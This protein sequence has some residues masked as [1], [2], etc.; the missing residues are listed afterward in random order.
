MMKKIGYIVKVF[1]RY[2]MM[3]Y[4]RLAV[5][6]LVI[7]VGSS[8]VCGGA[9]F[10]RSEKQREL[11]RELD[12]CGN[13]DVSVYNIDESRDSVLK[14]VSGIKSVGR[15]YEM[16]Y[17]CSGGQNN[18]I[19]AAA[20]VD[21][22]SKDIY[23][24]TC[25]DG[26]YPLN[27][28]EIAIDA[29]TAKKMGIMPQ[30]GETVNLTLYDYEKRPVSV[31]Q[32]KITGIFESSSEMALGGDLRQPDI[33][34]YSVPKVFLN[35]TKDS[36]VNKE[37]LFIQSDE[38]DLMTLC[39]NLS[40]IGI[41]AER[42]VVPNGRRYAYI[43]ALGIIDDIW[44]NYDNPSITNIYKAISDGNTV[45]D[46]YSLV[47]IPVFIGF[48]IIMVVTALNTLIRNIIKDRMKL[49]G[50][51]RSQGITA[52]EASV[53]MGIELV[54][55]TT[56]FS[57][58]GIA[59]GCGLHKVALCIVNAITG[60]GFKT[61]YNVNS[62]ISAVTM[63][64]YMSSFVVI[65]A[66]MFIA[67]IPPLIKSARLKPVNLLS[68]NADGIINDRQVR[69]S[70]N[71]KWMPILNSRMH[72]YSNGILLITVIC[73]SVAF[74]GY[75]YFH[76][77]ADKNNAEYKYELREAG[78]D[79][80][81]YTAGRNSHIA[82]G[83]LNTEN[84]HDCGIDRNEY[85]MISS[86]GYT[87][88]SYAIMKNSSTKLAYDDISDDMY[89]LMKPYSVRKYYDAA[90]DYERVMSEAENEVLKETGYSE[91]YIFSVPTVG[92]PADEVD[93]LSGCVIEGAIDKEVMSEGSRVIVAV[94]PEFKELAGSF[95]SVGDNLPLSDILLSPDEEI[96]NFGDASIYDSMTP[97]Y[98]N[99]I[100][101]EETEEYADIRG[102]AIGKRKDIPVSV[103]AIIVT[104]DSRY[105]CDGISIICVDSVYEKWGLP[106]NKYTEIG[107]DIKDDADIDKV[108]L[109]WSETISSCK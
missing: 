11:E 76:A 10:V 87:R 4:K 99:K 106:D 21:E 105:S 60:I 8:A 64:P 52:C 56:V 22:M 46:F 57:V 3:H 82:M 26:R 44:E 6:M 103:G 89:E 50:V 41:P 12:I 30:I 36:Y 85:E 48:I 70:K 39:R 104:E 75:T 47:I 14:D 109:D 97:V 68:G 1:S 16:G 9:L 49:F 98:E 79:E 55:L 78:L 94:S 62:I 40:Q 90:S 17:V 74:L 15:Y 18:Y 101:D 66:G 93:R 29:S 84:R 83:N 102:Y 34:N 42:M 25:T 24:M 72:L 43:Y 81:D 5:Y 80:F 28:D 107:I 13:Y 35:K 20:F 7:L 27:D 19:S 59:A 95:F 32:Y 65:L 108:E 77:L 53:F 37:S 73:M 88:N 58:V 96:C 23:H 63:N 33:E 86:R 67:M 51:L 54:L 69:K 45:K 91:K 31:R 100:Y 38:D 71:K 92:I 2:W 61:A